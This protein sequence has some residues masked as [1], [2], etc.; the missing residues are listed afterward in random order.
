M[1]YN[2]Y[3]PVQQALSGI[4]STLERGLSRRSQRELQA[5]EMDLAQEVRLTGLGLQRERLAETKRTG[6]VQR[7][8]SS[9]EADKLKRDAAF[10]NSIYIGT[11][12]LDKF[13]KLFPGL[14]DNE[15]NQLASS[16]IFKSNGEVNEEGDLELK[17][18]TW[19]EV[20]RMT[21]GFSEIY[22]T[23]NPDMDVEMF[24]REGGSVGFFDKKTG[25]EVEGFSAKAVRELS[26]FDKE[27]IK[28][29]NKELNGYRK[30]LTT[31]GTELDAN[32]MHRLNVG[33]ARVNKELIEIKRGRETQASPKKFNKPAPTTSD[34][35]GLF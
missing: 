12:D 14:S 22:N 32:E 28:R 17:G 19:G 33:V 1:P 10:E 34:P 5:T 25:K 30:K 23:L 8:V 31:E 27:K 7:E 26:F 24:T 16:L 29:L 6:A 11:I 35:L 21:K 4:G 15:R 18:K 9:L 3:A 2:P 20:L 13:F